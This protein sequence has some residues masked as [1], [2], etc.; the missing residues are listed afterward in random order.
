ML[1]ISYLQFSAFADSHVHRD[2]SKCRHK[3]TIVRCVD[4]II[5][6]GQRLW[7]I[8]GG[9]IAHNKLQHEIY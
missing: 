4:I 9:K 1:K 5:N 6:P 7:F 2:E 8:V 3:L